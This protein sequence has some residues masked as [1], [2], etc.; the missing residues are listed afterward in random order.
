MGPRASLPI[1]MSFM[2]LDN[3]SDFTIFWRL[4]KN[5]RAPFDNLW[6]ELPRIPAIVGS[7]LQDL[8]QRAT[9]AKELSKPR[10]VELAITTLQNERTNRRPALRYGKAEHS[11]TIRR[12]CWHHTAHFLTIRRRCWH[13]TAHYL[14]IRMNSLADPTAVLQE[15]ETAD[16]TADQR[17]WPAIWHNDI[18]SRTADRVTNGGEQA[19]PPTLIKESNDSEGINKNFRQIQQQISA[20]GQ[21]YGITG[22]NLLTHDR[23]E[24]YAS[25]G[26]REY[27]GFLFH[28]IIIALLSK[29]VKNFVYSSCALD[30][31]GC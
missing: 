9:W 24:L 23:K 17:P 19:T 7:Q 4:T 2:S 26:N 1:N 10:H 14:M 16:S 27:T 8:T 15:I 28:C 21:W 12:R 6:Q 3:L 13:H 5:P 20:R 30:E 31:W 11:P 22:N 25:E 29:L 18:H